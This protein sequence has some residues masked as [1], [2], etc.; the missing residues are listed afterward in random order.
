MFS[1]IC[2]TILLVFTTIISIP[3]A[4]IDF[5]APDI[6]IR[7]PAPLVLFILCS[8]AIVVYLRGCSVLLLASVIHFLFLNILYFIG[9]Q[10]KHQERNDDGSN[11]LANDSKYS[12]VKSVFVYQ[13]Y[14]IQI[15]AWSA[16]NGVAH[17]FVFRLTESN[18]WTL[19]FID[20]IVFSLLDLMNFIPSLVTGIQRRLPIGSGIKLN[21]MGI[22]ISLF[23]IIGL[24]LQSG[25]DI[26]PITLFIFQLMFQILTLIVELL[27]LQQNHI[28]KNRIL[29]NKNQNN[30][31]SGKHYERNM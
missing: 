29:S 11:S 30:N 9:C 21:I 14:Y 4:I 16:L 6:R 10:T 25:N 2:L 23:C 3:R 31:C 18:E 13:P 12:L 28:A 19:K 26:V 1:R 20:T 5:P 8:E 7:S 27:P 15:L 17:Y 24:Y 22:A